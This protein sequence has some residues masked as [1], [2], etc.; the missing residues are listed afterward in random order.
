[1]KLINNEKFSCEISKDVTLKSFARH[2]KLSCPINVPV[3]TSGLS[4]NG[5]KSMCHAN[6]LRMAYRYGGSVLS[7]LYVGNAP[8]QN[9]KVLYSHSV[10]I[11]PE[12][13][14]VCLTLSGLYEN[15]DFIPLWEHDHE[16]V[17]SFV[18]RETEVTI[19]SNIAISKSGY[20]YIWG[21]NE[22]LY[23]FDALM[24]KSVGEIRK[25]IKG[26]RTVKLCAGTKKNSFKSTLKHCG[27]I[28][29]QWSL[30]EYEQLG[31]IFI[32]EIEVFRQN[33]IPTD[34]T[35]CLTKSQ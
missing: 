31:E 33:V 15:I 35:I 26:L 1:M 12:G 32:P 24:E 19:P 3:R 34:E 5:T 21:V 4:S 13:K 29:Y 22:L 30:S 2:H 10:W 6:A 28:D 7:G 18:E 27:E 23:K 9:V 14:A 16:T 25:T 20:W 11:T 8:T 17:Q